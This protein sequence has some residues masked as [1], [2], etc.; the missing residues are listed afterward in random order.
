MRSLL[1]ALALVATQGLDAEA[2][3]ERDPLPFVG[4]QHAGAGRRGTREEAVAQAGGV[5]RSLL[6]QQAREGR[7]QQVVLAAHAPPSPA[8]AA[9]SAASPR[10][11][12]DFT[13]PSGRPVRAA[14][15]GCDK[16]SP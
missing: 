14:I 10:R 15:S 7:Q 6:G 9:R 3:E 8:R 4:P 12:C 13:V 11:A 1:P 2:G 5:G 16:S